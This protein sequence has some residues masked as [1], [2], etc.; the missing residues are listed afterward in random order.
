MSVDGQV[1]EQNR[2]YH[3]L[4]YYLAIK[5]NEMRIHATWQM[6][7]ESTLRSERRQTRRTARRVFRFSEA[8]GIGGC[9]G[10][11]KKLVIARC[12]EGWG[13]AAWWVWGFLPGGRRR[14]G[15]R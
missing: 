5:I 8:S 12:G 3:M 9:M 10:A 1:N 4:E 11:E 15:I 2:A 6:S 14:F 13:A 7:L